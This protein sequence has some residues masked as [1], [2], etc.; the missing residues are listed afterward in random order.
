MVYAPQSAA[1]S[2]KLPSAE[3]RARAVGAFN[4]WEFGDSMPICKAFRVFAPKVCRADSDKNAG[5]CPLVGELVQIEA[6]T[7]L[8]YLK[9][10]RTLTSQ[11]GDAIPAARS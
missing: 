10:L 4:R 7:N 6:A 9:Q 5:S 1:G 8:G 11:L 2:Q 3:Y